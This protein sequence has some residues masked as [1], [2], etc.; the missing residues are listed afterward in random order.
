M[1]SSSSKSLLKLP[2]DLLEDKIAKRLSM[3]DL[4]SLKST[5][6]SAN[7]IGEN[8]PSFKIHK[9]FNGVLIKARKTTDDVYFNINFEIVNAIR[10]HALKNTCLTM[11]NLIS[12]VSTKA[13]VARNSPI[14][15]SEEIY[16]KYAI[17]DLELSLLFINKFQNDIM[18]TYNLMATTQAT[19]QLNFAYHRLLQYFAT[20]I[21]NSAT[22]YI[23]PDKKLHTCF[24]YI[25]YKR[26]IATSTYKILFNK[27]GNKLSKSFLRINYEAFDNSKLSL[28]EKIDLCEKNHRNDI[29]LVT[30][31]Y[32]K[33]I[34]YIG[35]PPYSIIPYTNNASKIVFS[36]P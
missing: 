26:N 6:H 29:A 15:G 13:E 31:N 11:S 21:K 20:G 2:D 19:A 28:E 25:M 4:A 23:A 14:N 8:I 5:S 33:C 36:L 32:N 22:V 30:E 10:E 1:S 27:G 18:C 17:I 12:W 9:M 35:L 16:C 7:K 3:N 34:N 24:L